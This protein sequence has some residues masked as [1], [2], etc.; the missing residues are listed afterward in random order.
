MAEAVAIDVGT[1]RNIENGNRSLSISNAW[2][3]AAFFNKTIDYVFC[4]K[5]K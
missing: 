2:R 4:N 5:D 1:Y 3:I